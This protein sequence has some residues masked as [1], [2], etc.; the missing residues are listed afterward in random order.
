MSNASGGNNNFVC[1]RALTYLLKE[2][3]MDYKLLSAIYDTTNQSP[4]RNVNSY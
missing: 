1:G 4:F 3:K 2:V